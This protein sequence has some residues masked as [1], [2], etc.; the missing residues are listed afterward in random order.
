MVLLN[1]FHVPHFD[2]HQVNPQTPFAEALPLFLFLAA[3]LSGQLHHLSQALL[4]AVVFV[5]VPMQ[6]LIVLEHVGENNQKIMLVYV[7]SL[8]Q[9]IVQTIVTG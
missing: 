6:H 2:Q 7:A 9:E 4:M 8:H 1:Q 3:L 5:V